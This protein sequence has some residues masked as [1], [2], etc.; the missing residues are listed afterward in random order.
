M[1]NRHHPPTPPPPS[2]NLTHSFHSHF[3]LEK[4]EQLRRQLF[5][6]FDVLLRA[7]NLRGQTGIYI[8]VKYNI[9][10][11]HSSL[12]YIICRRSERGTRQSLCVGERKPIQLCNSVVKVQNG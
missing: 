5:A 8:P 2:F 10:L 12:V 4:T 7:H 6:L 1:M 3:N 9:S 11:V